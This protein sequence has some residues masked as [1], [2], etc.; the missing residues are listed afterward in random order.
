MQQ[1]IDQAELEEPNEGGVV[2]RAA[3]VGERFAHR[4]ECATSS[5]QAVHGQHHV[6]DGRHALVGGLQAQRTRGARL[7]ETHGSSTQFVGGASEID[8]HSRDHERSAVVADART[9]RHS[10]G[11]GGGEELRRQ[12]VQ[13]RARRTHPDADGDRRSM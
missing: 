1:L 4:V 10:G 5:L 6:L 12:A 11:I 7:L 3:G 9:R 8:A 13:V 2:L